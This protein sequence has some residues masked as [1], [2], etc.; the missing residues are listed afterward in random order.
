MKQRIFKAIIALL[1]IMTLTMANFLMLCANAVTY[2]VDVM[3][4][5]K[6]TNHKNV[7]F[8]AYFKDESGNKNTNLEIATNAE[9]LKLYFNI[10]VKREGYFNGDIVL[11]DANFKLKTDLVNGNINKI[12]NNKIYLNQINAGESKEIEVGIEIL[13]DDKFDLNLLNMKST[14]SL[15]G[16]YKDSTQEDISISA[17]KNVNLNFH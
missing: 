1:L 16:T 3:N 17:D 7:E 13:K 15:E 12:E 4:A 6:S 10:S 2:A 14:I 11:K 9:N 5:D 8:M